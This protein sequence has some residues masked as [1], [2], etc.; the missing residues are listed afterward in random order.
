M[1]LHFPTDVMLF[2]VV[3]TEHMQSAPKDPG[4]LRE[5]QR[6]IPHFIASHEADQTLLNILR[7]EQELGREIKWVASEYSLDKFIMG[8]TDL[9]GYSSQSKRLPNNLVRFC[10][11]QQKIAPIFWH[12]YL[13]Y[14]SPVLM[15]LGFRWDEQQ[16]VANWNCDKDRFQYYYMCD[17]ATKG[18]SWRTLEWRITQFPL[19]D[20]RID[21]TIINRFWERK[22]WQFPAV[23]N[24]RFCFFHSDIQ[25]QFQARVEPDNLQWWLDMEQQVGHAFGKRNLM[26][27]LEQPWLFDLSGNT[28]HQC[29]CT[30]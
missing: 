17:I 24:C 28:Q 4:L 26:S 21:K 27:R 6:R 23:S 13:Y 10:T 11:V 7:L 16:R 12:C 25:L 15:N 20:N 8:T 14:E 30:D 18:Y 22:G 9:P 29:L 2:A 19:Y 1:A 5:C 3:L